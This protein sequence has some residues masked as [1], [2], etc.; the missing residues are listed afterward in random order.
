[1]SIVKGNSVT[2]CSTPVAYNDSLGKRYERVLDTH[3]ANYG[4]GVPVGVFYQT[5]DAG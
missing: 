2:V 3:Q 5:G 4:T 1:M